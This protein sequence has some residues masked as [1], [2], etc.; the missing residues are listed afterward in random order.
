[1]GNEGQVV[2]LGGFSWLGSRERMQMRHMD[3]M[4]HAVC[5]CGVLSS[6]KMFYE[7]LISRDI[8]CTEFGKK[9]RSLQPG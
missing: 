4:F 7:H 5:V 3:N 2:L 6:F 9:G 8:R 1:M